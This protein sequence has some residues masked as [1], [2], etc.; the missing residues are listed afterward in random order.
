MFQIIIIT[1]IATLFAMIL[2]ELLFKGW[3]NESPISGFF[4][5]MIS[6]IDETKKYFLKKDEKFVNELIS[7]LYRD[8]DIKGF[9]KGQFGKGQRKDEEKRYQTSSEKL[10]TKPRL[11]LT[12][13]PSM[14][15]YSIPQNWRTERMLFFVKKGIYELMKNG[16]VRVGAGASIFTVPTASSTQ[17][18]I[19]S[20]RH[21]IKAVQILLELDDFSQIVK[22]VLGHMIDPSS[23]MQNEDGGW[24]Q[25]DAVF[26]ASDMW[27]SAYAM[28]FLTTAIDKAEKLKLSADQIN[29]IEEKLLLTLE[30]FKR[31][32]KT[33]K[34]SYGKVPKEENAPILFPEISKTLLKY[35]LALVHEFLAF[36]KNYLDPLR[37][38]KID[39]LNKL[40]I[41]GECAASARLS[42]CFYL[43]R[44]YNVEYENTWKPL[45]N[46]AFE[47][48]HFGY[49]SVDA[50]MLLD[51]EN[52]L[53][54]SPG[55]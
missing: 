21:T 19:V 42:Y 23:N 16:W 31:E 25:C 26:V 37:T 49:N 6:Y 20:Y 18:S 46:Y 41:V 50:A 55:C 51:I 45:F 2:F 35:D 12:C 43:A 9:H 5:W 53:I 24:K 27:G 1:I 30:W 17:G 7:Y 39:Y 44:D 47:R 52:H 15:L 33:S 4:Y 38:P 22:D 48:K 36:I 11:Y 10:D 32:W 3:D 54:K 34:W 8:L 28:E 14:V 13:R 40:K 29:S